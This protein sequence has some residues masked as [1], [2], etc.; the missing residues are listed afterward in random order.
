VRVLDAGCGIGLLGLSPGWSSVKFSEVLSDL[1][2]RH[3][4][5]FVGGVYVAAEWDHWVWLAPILDSFPVVPAFISVG[6]FW[7]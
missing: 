2:L 7:L 6:S 1:F 3:G 5:G 4:V